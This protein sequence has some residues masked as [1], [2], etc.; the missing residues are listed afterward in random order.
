MMVAQTGGGMPS[1]L[2]KTEC[3]SNGSLLFILVQVS[4]NI[5]WL[6]GRL[7]PALSQEKVA[8]SLLRGRRE[9]CGII[10]TITISALNEQS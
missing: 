6:L 8:R 3:I 4:T 10:T 2:R 1:L 9:E 5:D 7:A